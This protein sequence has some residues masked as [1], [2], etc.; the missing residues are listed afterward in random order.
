MVPIGVWRKLLTRH[1]HGSCVE[2]YTYRQTRHC[3]L[4]RR[5]G[6][7]RFYRNFRVADV[8]P[9]RYVEQLDKKYD[10]IE[11]YD[12]MKLTV[13]AHSIYRYDDT[14][15]HRSNVLWPRILTIKNCYEVLG[16]RFAESVV[17]FLELDASDANLGVQHLQKF[18]RWF[19]DIRL[20]LYSRM[21]EFSEV[22]YEMSIECENVCAETAD[23]DFRRISGLFRD[24]VEPCFDEESAVP[25]RPVLDVL[26]V[27]KVEHY[28]RV[29]SSSSSAS[30]SSK[31]DGY[32]AKIDGERL[33]ATWDGSVLRL[34]DNDHCYVDRELGV[35]LF[36]TDFVYQVERVGGGHYVITELNAVRNYYIASQDSLVNGFFQV[37]GMRRKFRPEQVFPYGLLGLGLSAEHVE[38]IHCIVNE[39]R[40][41]L[42]RHD[43]DDQS[44][45]PV[46]IEQSN[47]YLE[48][49]YELMR[50]TST[51]CNFSF[52]VMRRT[53]D[54]TTETTTTSALPCDGFLAYYRVAQQQPPQSRKSSRNCPFSFWLDRHKDYYVKQKVHQSV[55]LRYA[56]HSRT[57]A[58][59]LMCRDSIYF[60]ALDRSNRWRRY[61]G[62]DVTISDFS[63]FCRGGKIVEFLRITETELRFL[64]VR[65][66]K[67]LADSLNKVDSILFGRD[68]NGEDGED[69]DDDGEEEEELVDA[70]AGDDD[71][72]ASSLSSP[73]VEGS[74]TID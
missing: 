52:N 40:C 4:S 57:G 15:S 59:Y 55:E 64:R 70:A 47:R 17:R 42:S 60:T 24:L 54:E 38:R 3:V 44:L 35:Q 45:V 43:K 72:A 53:I 8:T 37:D 62:I 16:V 50:T 74:D 19:G 41:D 36:G 33:Y 58:R 1:F 22:C 18:C 56:V 67:L 68:F 48:A 28:I 10:G 2:L 71:D 61:D 27:N 69:G 32:K 30:S 51:V 29:L 73:S 46:T 13:C 23:A 66:D 11:C 49:C 65:E 26:L 12:E 25:L 14:I 9:K 7:R 6:T 21:N 20:A 31:A 5:V 34:S 63:D 39:G